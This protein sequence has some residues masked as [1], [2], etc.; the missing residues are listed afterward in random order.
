[1]EVYDAKFDKFQIKLNK[2]KIGDKEFVT[3]YNETAPYHLNIEKVTVPKGHFFVMG[4]NRDFSSDSRVWGFV[5][6]RY[7]RGSA[8]LIWFN[9]VYPWS[10]EEFHMRPTRIGTL[11]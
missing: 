6:F 3:A 8:F 2:A 7:I 9:M 1:M 11:L 10:Q 5:P 4:D